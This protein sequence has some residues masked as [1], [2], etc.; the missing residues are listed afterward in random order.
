VD[1][2]QT[3]TTSPVT[4]A[5][6][7]ISYSVAESESSRREAADKSSANMRM[8]EDPVLTLCH[9]PTP[10]SNPDGPERKKVRVLPCVSLSLL[11]FSPAAATSPPSSPQL[12]QDSFS[13]SDC[14]LALDKLHPKLPSEGF[15]KIEDSLNT[16]VAG[17]GFFGS[18]VLPILDPPPI[19][20][21]SLPSL[22]IIILS[23]FIY[24]CIESKLCSYMALAIE[25]KRERQR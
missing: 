10:G 18:T 4:P 23:F 8:I 25:K 9:F 3:L 13:P 24:Y 5:E 6:T 2:P 22:I 21:K 7:T 20:G 1:K 12:K 11:C 19:V 16:P 15:H 17:P 14:D